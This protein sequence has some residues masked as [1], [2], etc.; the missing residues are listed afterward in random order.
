MNTPPSVKLA[1]LALSG[2]FLVACGQSGGP[3]AGDTVLPNGM[4]VAEQI[5]LRQDRYERIGGAFK[6]INDQLETGDPDIAEIQAAAATLP[7]AGA[8]MADWFPEG[9]GP[10]AGVETEALPAIW[11]TPE[12]FDTKVA[13]FLAAAEELDTA[14][15]SGD[16]SAIASAFQATGGTCKA[17]HDDY[18]LDD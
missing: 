7:E 15:Q 6:T 14:A 9:T 11:E 8:G 5:E 16:V 13:E 4:T 10:D 1:A 12:D 2:L 17:C 3:D 18:R